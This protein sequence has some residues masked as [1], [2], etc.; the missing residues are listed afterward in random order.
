M[1][2]RLGIL[3]CLVTVILLSA[4]GYIAWRYSAADVARWVLPEAIALQQLSGLEIAPGGGYVAELDVT[5][6]QGRLRL[7][8]LDWRWSFAADPSL[9]LRLSSI[10]AADVTW[11]ATDT[12]G[13]E[14]SPVPSD[15]PASWQIADFR[16]ASWWPAIATVEISLDRLTWVAGSDELV[17]SLP[18]PSSLQSGSLAVSAQDQ[19][20][21]LGWQSN[22][23]EHWAGSAQLA[24]DYRI[25]IRWTMRAVSDEF[26]WQG[27][28]VA[29]DIVPEIELSALSAE[30]RL[31]L[32]SDTEA[33][34]NAPN[35]PPPF[36]AHFV[37]VAALPSP[38]D[39]RQLSIDGEMSLDPL[40]AGALVVTTPEL[41]SP[42]PDEQLNFVV[43]ATWEA[44][45]A[46]PAVTLREGVVRLAEVEW[47]ELV[48]EDF[49]TALTGRWNPATGE[50]DMSTVDTALSAAG[51]T[52][53]L[54]AESSGLSVVANKVEQQIS[55]YVTLTTQME[56]QAIPPINVIA[57]L[58]HAQAAVTGDISAFSPWGPLGEFQ[59][60]YAV[61]DERLDFRG[62]TDS[63]LWDW[64]SLVSEVRRAQPDL[65]EF[66]V[67][68][69]LVRLDTQGTYS[70]EG[71]SVAVVGRASEGYL[72]SGGVGLAGLNL[73][74]FELLL[75]NGNISPAAPISFSLEAVNTGVQ[76]TDLAGVILQD[77]KGW[78]LAHAEGSAL[79]GQLVIDQFR[80]FS[81]DGPLG[82][83]YLNEIDLAAVVAV[84]GTEGVDIQGRATASLPLVWQ[85]GNVLVDAG[86]LQGSPGALRYQPAVDPAQIDQRVGAVA[87]ALSNLQFEQL[88]A[89]ITLDEAGV[90]FLRTSVLGS[91]P[92][93]QNGRQVKLNLTLENN[94][95]NLLQSLQ[96]IESV[97]LWVTRKFEQK[98]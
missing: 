8:Q 89:D 27:D 61:Q 36:A 23:P 83:V 49:G 85:G 13:G 95:L 79:G 42:D 51:P 91:N 77:E 69:L 17:M 80:D 64:A 71:F 48:I 14:S 92:D 60:T 53:A 40:G 35:S 39:G 81:R 84:A 47:G 46:A 37:G 68:S 2:R 56:G 28:I 11:V 73:A 32:Y 43:D 82:T 31:K 98:K 3:L 9:P 88:E 21:S 5:L 41:T 29:P 62:R 57:S 72:T 12:A 15:A 4:V 52:W 90:M 58:R 55:G 25:D 66:E 74:P 59:L 6:P 20:F 26:V 19:H 78:V 38:L 10:A 93:Y 45:F 34:A 70:P 54:R 18:K 87:A 86:R 1:L 75:I 33:L 22:G 44:G 65:T 24:G 67:T 50:G 63:V 94:L 30:V 76:I 16:E 7:S 96:T 97:N